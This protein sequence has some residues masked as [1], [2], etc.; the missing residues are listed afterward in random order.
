M[1]HRGDKA[2]PV[3]NFRSM[4]KLRFCTCGVQEQGTGWLEGALDVRS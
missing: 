2:I 3:T 1:D 4:L